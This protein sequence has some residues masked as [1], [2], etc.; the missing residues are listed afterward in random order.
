M[1]LKALFI[2]PGF[3]KDYKIEAANVTA[4]KGKNFRHPDG[5]AIHGIFGPAFELLPALACRTINKIT[6]ANFHPL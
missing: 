2:Y 6:F 4:Q 5:G 1:D 3:A